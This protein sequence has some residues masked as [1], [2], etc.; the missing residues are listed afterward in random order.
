M[1]RIHLLL[2]CLCL[3]TAC[4]RRPTPPPAANSLAPPNR[5]ALDA[6]LQRMRERLDLMHSVARVKWNAQ[7]PIHDPER[8]RALLQEIVQRAESHS[9]DAEVTRRFFTAQMEAAKLV[10]EDDFQRWRA[11]KQ[12][13]FLDAPTLPTLRQQ[14]DTLNRALLAAL[15]EARPYLDS[16]AGQADLERRAAE[17]LADVPA[18]ARDAALRPLRRPVP[19]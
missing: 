1:S 9:M 11:A 15:A 2:L 17:L 7:T 19:R 6:L 16:A 5:A 4:E 18:P 13:S 10:Q 3:L 12:S 8:E 14:I